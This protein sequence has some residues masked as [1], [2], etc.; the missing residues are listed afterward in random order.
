MKLWKSDGG[1]P[2]PKQQ[3]SSFE[4]TPPGD[5]RSTGVLRTSAGGRRTART[6]STA[7]RPYFLSGA[8]NSGSFWSKSRAKPN[9]VITLDRGLLAS[10]TS[11]AQ[12]A[13][14]MRWFGVPW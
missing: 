5:G 14:R 13:T 4:P 1:S 9:D 10:A 11:E 12:L 7:A 8:T 3:E 6:Y 2:L